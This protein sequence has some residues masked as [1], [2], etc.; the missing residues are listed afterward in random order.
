M[1]KLAIVTSHPVQYNAPLFRLL[2]QRKKV[3]VKVFYTWGQTEQGIVYDPDFKKEIKWDIPLLDGYEKEFVK[4]TASKPN[5]GSFTGI[6]NKDLIERIDR[7]NPDALLLFGWSFKSHLQVLRYYKDKKK[8]LFRG[9][10]NLLD[11]PVGF[12]VKKMFR[13]IFL[14]WVYKHIN[15]ALYTGIANKKYY[16]AHGLQGKQLVYAPHAVEN[17]RFN[18]IDGSYIQRAMQWRK[19]LGIGDEEIV[20][21]FAGKLEFKKDPL[22]LINAF[23]ELRQKEIRLLVVGNGALETELKE[24]AKSDHRI[25]FLDFQNQQMMPVVYRLANVFVL[26][27]KG[28]GETWGLSVNE[29]MACSLPVLVSNKCG[30]AKDVVSGN[31][32]IFEA[33][34]K[35]GLV[36]ALQFFITGKAK[37]AAMGTVSLT[38]IQSFSLNQIATAVEEVL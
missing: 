4:N 27:S 30:C 34:N 38:T 17:N 20:F 25:L 13:R 18:D 19:E 3:A 37:L 5:A 7:Y 29:A 1:K 8:I 12:S 24:A 26:P 21:L 36:T 31:G 32:L 2:S 16:L 23:K 11:E 22:L 9:D 10:S 28:P 15:T 35:N 14:T 33:G 6:N